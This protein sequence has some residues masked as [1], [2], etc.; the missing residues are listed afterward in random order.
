MFGPDYRMWVFTP[1]EEQVQVQEQEQDQQQEQE[2]ASNTNAKD[3]SSAKAEADKGTSNLYYLFE[4][5]DVE[6]DGDRT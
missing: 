5:V 1:A 3:A 4:A 6:G 2:S